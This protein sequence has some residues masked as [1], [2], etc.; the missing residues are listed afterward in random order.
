MT[1][2]RA[3]ADQAVVVILDSPESI[4]IDI[5]KQKEMLVSP[6]KAQDSLSK[7]EKLENLFRS[8]R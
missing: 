2:R 6:W 5:A 3:S 4:V 7:T 1:I 8:N